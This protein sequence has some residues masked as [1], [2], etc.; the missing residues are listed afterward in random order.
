[1][2]ARRITDAE[3][4]ERRSAD[5][6]RLEHAARALLDS[7]GWQRWVRVRATNGLA[8]YSF[9]NQLLIALQQPEATYVAGFRAFLTLNR[10]VRKG[11]K[12][13]R[14]LAPMT[15]SSRAAEAEVS[16]DGAG[17]E[18]TPRR[19]VFRAVNVFDVAQTDPLADT[20]PVPLTAP[21]QPV[22]GDSHEHLLGPLQQ[23]AGE[24]G[25]TVETR[26][27]VDSAEGFCDAQ[28]KLIV[29]EA[30]LPA[31]ARLRVLVHEIA[32]ALGVGYAEYGRR[33]AEVMVDTATFIV[34]GS[35]GLDTSGST[36]PYIAGWGEDG[37][38]EAIRAYAQTI[39]QIARRIEGAFRDSSPAP[40][41]ATEATV[42]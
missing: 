26:V 14:I 30:T 21:S 27:I 8:R 35:L 34:C 42:A 18:Q 19:T 17:A 6:E 22:S 36:V 28:R 33:Q 39:D 3:R 37:A 23:L 15:L 13:I 1:M 24:L 5:R 4:A 7:S 12:A 2:S 11:E 9:H 16:G 38:L 25:Y 40:L 31:N 41:G 10:C 20:D 29:V 32:H